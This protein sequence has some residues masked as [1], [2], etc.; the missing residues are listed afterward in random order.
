[1]VYDEQPLALIGSVDSATTHLAEQ[2]VAKANLP[3][4]SPIATD[5]SVTLAGVSWMFSCAPTDDAIAHAVAADIARA[6][7]PAAAHHP[8]PS[9]PPPLSPH[10]P[11][12]LACL[13]TTDHESRMIARELLRELSRRGHPPDFRFDVPPGAHDLS[14]Q[15]A[16]LQTARPAAVLIVAGA[17]DA[18]RL[19]RAVRQRF[20]L[21]TNPTARPALA[22]DSCIIFG[23]HSMGHTRFRELAGPAAEG[24]RFPL[25]A[26]PDPADDSAL[27]FAARFA[28]EHH[29]PPDSAAALAYDA[30]RLLI[31]AIRQAGPNRARIRET[32]LRLSPWPGIAGPIEFDGTG[33]NTRTNIVMAT[34]HAS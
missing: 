31:E 13:A 20:P 25:L 6:L 12:R 16:A 32:L 9:Q 11:H 5:K 19:A 29:H 14:S 24:I 7:A 10:A 3:L 8:P 18:A 21:P 17:E 33:R 34:L 4:L 22:P 1:M 2:V 30:T 26:A 27:R 23:T 15:L 28:A